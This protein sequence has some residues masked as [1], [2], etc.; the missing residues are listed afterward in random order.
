MIDEPQGRTLKTTR[1]SLEILTLILEYNGLTLAELD[2]MVESPKSSI[3]SHLNTLREKRYL[4]KENGTYKVSFRLALLGEQVR[5]RYPSDATIEEKV[6]QLAE[7]TGEET[8]FTIF[9]H[10]RLLMFYGTSGDAAAKESDIN[11]RSEYYLHNTAAGKA[12]LAELDHDQVERIV[13]KWGLPQE[14]EATITDR[15]RLFEELAEIA[16]RGYGTV[17]E[18]F[19]PG[20]VAVGA[21]VHDGEGNI[22]GGLSVGG[23][24]Y[25]VDQSRIEQELAE[26]LLD[27]AR[28]LESALQA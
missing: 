19:A 26:Q 9:E 21:P 11:Y 6:E 13:D 18:E 24:K 15:D 20:L 28:S 7:R 5:Y 22:I 3:H 25:R 16:A 4:V 10:G 23:P 1:R 8:N 14:S 17:D 12:I 27:S 2:E